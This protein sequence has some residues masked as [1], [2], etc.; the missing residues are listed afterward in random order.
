M[1]KILSFLILAFVGLSLVIAQPQKMTYQTVVRD[2]N[3]ELVVNQQVGVR[4]SILQDHINGGAAYIETH[5]A[6]TNAN[7]LFSIMVGAGTPMLL[8]NTLSDVD[9]PN[10]DY[11]LR[12]EIDP[13]GGIN[14]SITGTQQLISVP[15][16]FYAAGA[17]SVD[18]ANY[19]ITSDFNNLL[20]RPTGTNMGDIIYWDTTTTAW[21]ILPVGSIG[22]VLTLD[23]NYVPQWNTGGSSCNLP[24]V[25]TDPV[26]SYAGTSANVSGA[27][28]NGGG[29]PFVVGGFCWSQN[30]NPTLSD[31]Y[32][33]DGIGAT[34]F[35][36]DI[37]GLNLGTTY[38]FRAYGMNAAGV[39]YGADETFTTWDYPAV[40][41]YPTVSTISATTAYC[42]GTV[43]ADGGDY[44]SQRGVCWSTG[45][46]PD[47]DNNE[48][49]TSDGGGTGAFTSYMTGL[50]EGTT[51]YVCAYAINNVGPVYGNTITFTTLRTPI[52]VT[53]SPTSDV[54]DS[55]AVSGGNVT[56]DGGDQVSN[57]GIIWSDAGC[58]DTNNYTGM[59]SHGAGNAPFFFTDTMKNLAH[60][61]TYYVVAYAKNSIGISYGDCEQFQTPPAV[62]TVTTGATVTNITASTAECSGELVDNGNDTYA[63]VGLCWDTVALPVLGNNNYTVD[64]WDVWYG[65]PYQFYHSLS[66]L[67]DGKT[68]YVRAYA[69]NQADTVYGAAV[70][71]NTLTLPTVITD[72]VVNIGITGANSGGHVTSGGSYSSISAA[73][74]CWDTLPNPVLGSHNY[75]EDA[76]NFAPLSY[77]SLLFDLNDSTT[78]YVRAYATTAAGTGYG[79]QISFTTLGIKAC[80]GTP[81]VTDYDGNVYNTVQIGGRC[82]MRENLR[83]THYDDGRDITEAT[84][85][86]STVP[87]RYKPSCSGNQV[88]DEYG[89]LY[90]WPAVMDGA[91]QSNSVPSGVQGVCPAGWHVPST[92]EWNLFVN[93]VRGKSSWV[94]NSY[95]SGRALASQNGWGYC[96]SDQCAVG[97]SAPSVT[98]NSSGF[99]ILPAGYYYQNGNCSEDYGWSASFWSCSNYSYS[100]DT[101]HADYVYISCDYSDVSVYTNYWGD[102]RSTYYGLSVRCVQDY[103]LADGN[104]CPGTPT[105]S[106]NDGHTYNTVEING[107]CW[108]KE[109]LRTTK[110][111]DGTQITD[112][113]SYGMSSTTGYFYHAYNNNYV[114]DSIYGLF[115]NW[116]AAMNYSTTPGA[117]GICPTGWHIPTN[118]DVSSLQQYLNMVYTC[119]GSYFCGALASNS[120][121][122]NSTSDNCYVGYNLQNNNATNFTAQPA[123]YYYN[124]YYEFSQGA[125]FWE[126]YDPW[127]DWNPSYGSQ[128][129]LRYNSSYLDTGNSCCNGNRQQKDAGVSVRCI[130]D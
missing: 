119:N 44:V 82:W 56:S 121:W 10:H 22:E 127:N 112:G 42:G 32:S 79:Q 60:L 63:E 106:D 47:V 109:N 87:L 58:P 81:T 104:S 9:W 65:L 37:T 98:K 88:P 128:M 94:C 24:T 28:T 75:S 5:T 93:Y 31:P 68:Y 113:A 61:Q 72:P 57:Y 43:T 59:T 111:P 11:F 30:A 85:I 102:G 45:G 8:G 14:Y 125:Y 18:T 33:M 86:N 107:Q 12:V 126:S 117:Q 29:T 52:I 4:V 41:T 20:N 13:A 80:P 38:H 39:A 69:I 122:M 71:F 64:Y 25:V 49:M 53:N 124:S 105:V 51:Y 26:N 36:H 74:V 7:G 123:G 6:T 103:T 27:V 99:S 35:T 114:N 54:T 66:G 91:Q 78:Y 115:Y 108:M 1:K 110:Y 120:Y 89:Y 48:G 95:N 21:R 2:A 84:I 23:S 62:P 16:A 15:Y 40:T 77:S 83:T 70:S 73:G 90:N 101:L 96:S 130:K 100:S 129:S 55:S 17:K 116:P 50:Q 34:S 76:S 97:S 118:S 3:N 46:N 92:N 67:V 19:A